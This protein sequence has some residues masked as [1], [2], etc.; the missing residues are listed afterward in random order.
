MKNTNITKISLLF[1][2]SLF[3]MGCEP[4]FSNPVGDTST[5]SNGDADFSNY[6]S[7]GDSL[8]A[9]YADGALYRSGQINSFPNILATQFQTVGG[10]AFVQPLMDDN[11]GGLLFGT[12]ANPDFGNRLVLNG[13][14]SSPAPIAGTPI[15]EVIIGA[16]V[17][18]GTFNNMGVPGAKSFHLG[19]PGYGSAAGLGAG[20]ANPYFVRFASTITTTVITDAATQAPT[21]F[22]LWIGNNDVLSYATGG[23]V[24]TNQLGNFDPSTYGSSDITDP[25]VFAITFTGLLGALTA[26]PATKGILANIPDVSTIPFFTTVPYNAIALVDDETST[27][28]QKEAALNAGYATYNATLQSLN[29]TLLTAEE[30]AARTITFSASA[31]NPM[32]IID[33]TLTDLT[34]INP[35][36]SA[37]LV[38]MR[39]ATADDLIVLTALTKIRTAG[40][41]SAVPL[42]DEDVLIPTEISAVNTARLA[43]NATIKAAADANDNLAFYDAS[44]FMAALQANGI[45]YGTGN[46]T[47]TY[48]S[49]GAFSLDGVH[50]TARGYSLIANGMIDTINAAFNS[51]IPRV[52]PGT[53]TTIFLK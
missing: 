24:G 31:A 27:A 47:S 14:T 34:G 32:V 46:V 37:A 44:A 13:A 35:P 11:L 6:V 39:Q 18:T 33:E 1:A 9:G 22:S 20:T 4:E 10:G 12:V 7:V 50:P 45:D 23:G 5:Y 36:A 16:P 43:F 51:S 15:N 25:N 8:T 21:F 42:G 49:G 52:D 17:L 19:A 30:V 3:L 40:G 53:Y 2:S 26:N 41:G 28:L 29:G 48:G 38:N